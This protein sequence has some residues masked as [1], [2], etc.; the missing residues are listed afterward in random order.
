MTST[1]AN[2][3]DEAQ[4]LP[5]DFH[6]HVYVIAISRLCRFLDEFRVVSSKEHAAPILQLL[7]SRVRKTLRNT[8][9]WYELFNRRRTHYAIDTL[10]SYVLEMEF[11]T[12]IND[13]HMLCF[14][15]HVCPHADKCPNGVFIQ[16][17]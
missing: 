6:D 9:H 1:G 8:N 11:A 4:A 16:D 3:Q 5:I 7:E 12:E 14:S 17:L 2:V 15:F 10:H 13:A